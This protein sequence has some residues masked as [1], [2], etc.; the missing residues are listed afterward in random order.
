[1]ANISIRISQLEFNLSGVFERINIFIDIA[2]NEESKLFGLKSFYHY[3]FNSENLAFYKQ[4][5]M[6]GDVIT[7]EYLGDIEERIASFLFD[8]STI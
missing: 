2:E 8:I 7:E 1:M 3:G 6:N 4:K 5:F